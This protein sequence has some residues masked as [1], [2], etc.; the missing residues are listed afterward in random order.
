M[1][2]LTIHLLAAVV[3]VIVQALLTNGVGRARQGYSGRPGD[4]YP[5]RS[6]APRSTR[7]E[8]YRRNHWRRPRA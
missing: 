3:V 1:N 8:Q 5:Q 6:G 4:E 2:R 7:H